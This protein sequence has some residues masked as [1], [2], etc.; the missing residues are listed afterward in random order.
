MVR[1]REPIRNAKGERM[2]DL[3]WTEKNILIETYQE[4][5]VKRIPLADETY[6]VFNM[7]NGKERLA[8]YDKIT[9]LMASERTLA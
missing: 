6:K 2:F 1:K 7:L 4:G 3:V 8:L 9:K 5:N